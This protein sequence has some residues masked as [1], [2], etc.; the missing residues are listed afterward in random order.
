M[1]FAQKNPLAMLTA[2]ACAVCAPAAAQP[3]T[4]TSITEL[5]T[6]TAPLQAVPFTRV[7]IDDAFWKPRL[8][9]NRRVSLPHS[10]QMVEKVGNLSNL[11]LAAQGKHEGYR[12]PYYIDSDLYKAIEAVS[13]SL[14]SH[15][16]AE[17]EARLDHIIALIAKAQQPDGYLNTWVQVVAPDQRWKNLKDKHERYCAGHLIEAAV[18]H[19]AATG[20]RTLLDVAIKFA[21]Y[22]DSVFGD[23]PG[24]REGYDGHEEIKI[25]L[26]KLWR[27]T[28][29]QRYFDLAEYFLE[30]RGT[31]FFA[32]EHNTPL[33][34]YNGEY[35][36]DN[37]R[38]R[39]HKKIVG[40]AVRA[41]YL[42][43]AAT[44]Y[45]AV[46]QDPTLIEA[47][48]RVWD[49]TTGANMY[50][51]G[52]IGSSAK[53]EGFTT[54]Y[55][56]PNHTAYQE[57]CASVAMI[58]WNHRL[59]LLHRDG[60]Y[61]DYLE[62]ALYNGFLAGV[63]L[64]GETFF[65]VNPL[66][67][68]GHHHRMP[69]YDT[70]CC[71]PNVTRTLSQLGG[72]LYATSPDALWVN[73][74]VQGAA[75]TTVAGHDV[76]LKVTTDYPWNGAV[77]LQPE[78]AAPA[79]FALKL[80]VPHWAESVTATVNGEAVPTDKR[81]AGYLVIEREWQPGDRVQL[82][83]PMPVRQVEADPRVK[84]NRSRLALQRGPLVYC[85]EQA[86]N[87]RPVSLVAVARGAEL[88]PHPRPDLLG[89]IVTLKGEGVIA[90]PFDPK[91]HRLYGSAGDTESVEIMAVPYYAWDNRESG[92]M[93]VWLPT[94]P[95]PAPVRGLEQ[96]AAVSVSF[97]N[98]HAVP[99]GANDGY[100]VAS[101]AEKNGEGC[102]WWPHKGTSEW[103]Q[104][105]WQAPQQ[106]A[107]ARVYWFDDR[108]HGGCRVPESWQIE[109]L[110]GDEW[111]PVTL[112]SGAYDVPLNG[113][114]E[115]EFAPVHTTALRLAVKLQ[116]GYSGGVQEW[117]VFEKQ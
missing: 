90:Q 13:Y 117:Q 24:K 65:Y 77:E 69:W 10:M 23:E 48:D 57:T 20:K 55:D 37:A 60:K 27:V 66:A 11:E 79:R 76:N 22:I 5:S 98:E 99:E 73:L 81:D 68:R 3:A 88:T 16:D 39:E 89:G 40:H 25:A 92:E 43:S 18:A 51:T 26:I 114:C 96:H 35:W 30:A 62:R 59:N 4:T 101:S 106:A 95:P 17:L 36:Q 86:D 109:Y 108:P 61:I 104:Y 2:L 67:S 105:T 52:G 94:A 38:I 71:P 31:G 113:W 49:N 100:E 58:M 8:E 47:I 50:V 63:A 28:G 110:D 32:R 29:E 9:T 85:L 87:S 93:A 14:A 70:A 115:V 116:T 103:V 15:P 44:D 12:G 1:M 107:S 112:T 7:T 64:D 46:K 83:L 6:M 34:K 53:N 21:D 111:K 42:F 82:D 56:L 72:Y 91:S 54:D 74:Y 19:H 102:H 75:K 41:V 84:D 78:V 45:A 80:R 97:K 33:D